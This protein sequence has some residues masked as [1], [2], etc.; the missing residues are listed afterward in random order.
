MTEDEPLYIQ[1]NSN[2]IYGACACFTDPLINELA[3]AVRHAEERELSGFDAGFPTP[4]SNRMNNVVQRSIGPIRSA[5]Q[6]QAQDTREILSLIQTGSAVTI[7]A[8][9]GGSS[10]G[11]SERVSASRVAAGRGRSSQAVAEPAAVLQ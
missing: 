7:D 6:Q 2:P 10:G 5:V 3:A 8:S 1:Y 11:S 4:L 9:S